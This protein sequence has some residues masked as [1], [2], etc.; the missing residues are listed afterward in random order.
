[1]KGNITNEKPEDIERRYR[2][3][4]GFYNRQLKKL[5]EKVGIDINLTSYVVR[6]TWAN[7]AYINNVDITVISQA[8]GH[9]SITTTEI[10]IKGINADVV[11]NANRHLLK[12]LD[13]VDQAKKIAPLT[14]R[15]ESQVVSSPNNVAKIHIIY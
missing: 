8:L 14:K 10:Y 6:H 1:M 5:G 3:A 4:L 2:N 15:C 9:S 12:R 13:C 7:E 11:F